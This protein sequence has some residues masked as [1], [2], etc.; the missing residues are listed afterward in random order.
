[1]EQT[2]HR[3]QQRLPLTGVN[4]L[5]VISGESQVEIINTAIT[6]PFSNISV[7]DVDNNG[8]VL[9]GHSFLFTLT[10]TSQGI[11]YYPQPNV[12]RK[13]G[14]RYVASGHTPE[15]ATLTSQRSMFSTYSIRLLSQCGANLSLILELIYRF[16]MV[17]KNL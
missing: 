12:F 2:A 5:P 7:S 15:V 1:M 4:D 16:S 8:K 13:E 17:M 14:N 9:A 10:M 3:A 11:P 6:N